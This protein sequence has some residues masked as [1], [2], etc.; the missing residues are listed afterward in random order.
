MPSVEWNA[1]L[2]D[3]VYNWSQQGEEWSA[4]WGG[5]EAQW[6]G[7]ILPRIH[8]FVPAGTILEIAPGFGRWTNYLKGL[9]ERLVV[10]DL[11]GK[12]IEACQRR[13]GSDSNIVYYVNDGR[14]LAMI[15]DHSIDFAFS[16]DSLVHAEADVIEAYLSQLAQKLKPDGVGFIHHSNLGAY[17][18]AL[19]YI[20]QI[21]DEWRDVVLDRAFLS[22]THLRAESMTAELFRKFCEQGGLQTMSQET[23]NWGTDRLLIDCFSVFNLKDSNWSRPAKFLNNTEFMKEVTLIGARSALYRLSEPPAL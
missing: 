1:D 2:W 8:A 18:P 20:R 9:C 3:S 5:S 17:A 13:F 19:S 11:S 7:T 12:C 14:S 4:A 10:V 21:P 22:P 16:F 15:P 23:V 6:F